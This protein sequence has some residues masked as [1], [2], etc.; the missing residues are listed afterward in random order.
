[1]KNDAGRGH[2]NDNS[3][4]PKNSSSVIRY[5]ND[6]SKGRK[7]RIYEIMSHKIFLSLRVK[8]KMHQGKERIVLPHNLVI[9]E[10]KVGRSLEL[11]I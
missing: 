3:M 2:D 8:Q 6:P 11:L 7:Y 10:T 1:M 4:G 9:E 5:I